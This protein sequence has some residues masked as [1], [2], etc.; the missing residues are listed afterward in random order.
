MGKDNDKKSAEGA[1]ED[2]KPKGWQ[3]TIVAGSCLQEE[4]QILVSASACVAESQ[5]LEGKVRKK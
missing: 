5:E 2:E 1:R 3:L 4:I